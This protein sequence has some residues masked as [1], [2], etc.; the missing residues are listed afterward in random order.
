MNKDDAWAKATNY[1]DKEGR[2]LVEFEVIEGPERG[3]KLYK[4]KCNI[5]VKTQVMTPVGP[6]TQ[7]Q[8]I[9]FEFDF[10]EGKT[11]NWCKKNFDS[12]AD[13]A[14]A[15]WRKIQEKAQREKMKEV[16]PAQGMPAM[17]G[18]DGKPIQPKG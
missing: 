14:V 10:P 15:E 5:R 13:S 11:F 2:C 7:E 4:G 3:K 12:E 9:P 6:R 18:P 8:Q 1:H 16:V 17:L